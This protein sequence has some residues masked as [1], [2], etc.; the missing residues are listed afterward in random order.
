MKSCL[1]RLLALVVYDSIVNLRSRGP[2]NLAGTKAQHTP[3]NEI[4]MSQRPEVREG[5]TMAVGEGRKRFSPV[6]ATW[7]GLQRWRKISREDPWKAESRWTCSMRVGGMVRTA[8][9]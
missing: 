1:T 7:W 4:T 8:G 9:Q 2:Q 6:R 3:L 5:D